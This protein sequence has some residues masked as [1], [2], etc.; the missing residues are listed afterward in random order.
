MFC[1]NYKH[2]I[3][4][5]AMVLGLVC[6]FVSNS[7]SY[8][9]PSFDRAPAKSTL[10]P[11]T[12]ITEPEF[13]EKFL[14]GEFLLAHEAVNAYIRDQIAREKEI[15]KKDWGQRAVQ[16]DVNDPAV[17][18]NFQQVVMGLRSVMVVRISGLLAHTG[19]F[20]HIG[21]SGKDYGGMPVIYIDS[22][23]SPDETQTVLRHEIDELL[24]WE[25]LRVNGLGIDRDAMRQWIRGHISPD[26]LPDPRLDATE[27][28][29]M[30]SRQIAELFHKSAFLLQP[31][32]GHFVDK[33][34]FNYEYLNL[35]LSLYGF[36][37]T[38]KDVNLAAQMP[39]SGDTAHN[40]SADGNRELSIVSPELSPE[41]PLTAREVIGEI[42]SI[43]H[44]QDI[45]AMIDELGMGEGD[46][47]LLVGVSTNATYGV[48]CAVRAARVDVAQP[49]GYLGACSQ[50]ALLQEYTAVSREAVEYIYGRDL[51]GDRIDMES[52]RKFVQ[53]AGLPARHYSYIFLPNVLDDPYTAE[54]ERVMGAV[55]DALT[56]R[57]TV[58]IGSWIR[59]QETIDLFR[60]YAAE[61]GY[62]VEMGRTFSLG[63]DRMQELIVTRITLQLVPGT[64]EAVPGSRLPVPRKE[65][66][67]DD[68]MSRGNGP[69]QADAGFLDA[70]LILRDWIVS[71]CPPAAALLKRLNDWY[72]E[73]H[74]S[75]PSFASGKT[76]EGAAMSASEDGIV[77]LICQNLEHENFATFF[78][79]R[80]MPDLE[81]AF[82]R[83]GLD[84]GQRVTVLAG[85][86]RAGKGYGNKTKDP[87]YDES[88]RM[89]FYDWLS[90]YF[91]EDPSHLPVLAAL[92][93]RRLVRA[94]TR[95]ERQSHRDA[96]TTESPYPYSDLN[97][98]ERSQSWGSG[99]D[100]SALSAAQLVLE[101]YFHHQYGDRKD[102][103]ASFFDPSR[104]GLEICPG[105]N[106]ISCGLYKTR[107][108]ADI[109]AMD[110]DYRAVRIARRLY[111][112]EAVRADLAQRLPYP[113]SVF[114]YV[115][116]ASVLPYVLEAY[117]AKRN[118]IADELLRITRP[119]GCHA[120][121]FRGGLV[122]D[123]DIFDHLEDGD[124]NGRCFSL[125]MVEGADVHGDAYIRYLDF[126]AHW[127]PVVS[128]LVLVRTDTPLTYRGTPVKDLIAGYPGSGDILRDG[129]FDQA[130]SDRIRIRFLK[131]LCAADRAKG[132]ARP[133]TVEMLQKIA[134]TFDVCMIRQYA[135]GLLR[136]FGIKTEDAKLEAYKEKCHEDMRRRRQEETAGIRMGAMHR[137]STGIRD[138][139]GPAPA[140]AG[141]LDALRIV[142][143]WIA[144]LCPPAAAFL[145]NLLEWYYELHELSP[146]DTHASMPNPRRAQFAMVLPAKADSF[147]P[148]HSGNANQARIDEPF[149]GSTMHNSPEVR[150]DSIDTPGLLMHGVILF[151]REAEKNRERLREIFTGGVKPANAVSPELRWK[152]AHR[153]PDWVS[154]SMVGK[155]GGYRD[156]TTHKSFGPTNGD[157]GRFYQRLTSSFIA[158]ILDPA[159]VR[160]H[161]SDFPAVGQ[162]FQG[163]MGDYHDASGAVFNGLEYSDIWK[164]DTPD[165]EPM[166]DEVWSRSIPPDAIAA[167]IVSDS[168]APEVQHLL[169][170]IPLRR[171]LRVFNPN[172]T[173]L[174]EV[175]RDAVPPARQIAGT[176]G[177]TLPHDLVP[178]TKPIGN[179]SPAAVDA[180]ETTPKAPRAEAGEGSRM[181]SQSYGPN[182][183]FG[184]DTAAGPRF[185]SMPGFG[186]SFGNMA[187]TT[188]SMSRT[189]AAPRRE[190]DGMT[191]G[192][193]ADV[194]NAVRT[195]DTVLP[196]LE[197]ADQ[198][199]YYSVRYDRTRIPRGSLAEAVL[200]TYV[201]VFLPCG[202]RGKDRVTLDSS[203]KPGQGLIWVECYADQARSR[204]IGEGHVD[205][206]G[207]IAAV[208]L[209]IP[210]MMDIALVASHIPADNDLTAADIMR[211]YDKPLSFIRGRYRFI[212]GEIL[213]D[214]MLVE[215]TLKDPAKGLRL[216]LPHA[217]PI[218][219]DRIP[220]YY[221]LTI[222]QL[223]QSA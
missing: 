170:Q 115:I 130:A 84:R 194:Q 122:V 65:Y 191:D 110:K 89:Y 82:D 114:D 135:L 36:D 27:F 118:A 168:Y 197:K 140:D 117:P 137:S 34:D 202:M 190:T 158:V 208:A 10:S 145:K 21:L 147:T 201:N 94:L 52:Y 215:E 176:P 29:G 43:P 180:P 128:Y 1:S 183:A 103:A 93:P 47:V 155:L 69:A 55:L 8:A 126:A 223:N 220:A 83:A 179:L 206:G 78:R 189:V 88:S 59:K 106:S 153:H 132:R 23:F 218:P 2:T 195:R 62:A 26:S 161:A 71:L 148:A 7:V 95:I 124:N 40:S 15:F 178:G 80:L 66:K 196:E 200:E 54:R 136:E 25:N 171:S 101:K 213:T 81:N 125:Y 31:L 92:P 154:L 216:M 151:G 123:D 22:Q 4:Y 111:G 181:L 76:E 131:A 98:T 72:F 214:K 86:L 163:S 193:V 57:G 172:G 138:N 58:C 199:R 60:Q 51:V 182:A 14:A 129:V 146:P 9:D 12:Q 152:P 133:E 44:K 73:L 222:K 100:A 87:R 28:R 157:Y 19:Q 134:E 109:R 91:W 53:D 112:V 173:V 48:A 159:Y 75:G 42:T 6:L 68:G 16:L 121:S 61:N 177:D 79:E 90:Y 107:Y 46:N 74:E 20:A 17:R 39:A 166:H 120:Y 99:S 116:A 205:I 211:D 18:G 104:K 169:A 212:T 188:N 113:D 144:S 209:R 67:A 167:I 207:D 35:M 56:D 32:Y 45:A 192:I 143:D 149:F 108:G 24:Q 156:T 185:L 11:A 175:G 139:S 198:G 142:R 210:A 96:S 77:S 165:G 219:P 187:P 102:F 186:S 49:D 150:I 41:L 105:N 70:L 13:R 64:E 33:V 174:F 3:L 85:L 5:R 141:F 217:A 164:T 127:V 50:T 221:E 38:A 97:T 160:A 63:R 184:S 30:T 119:G 204:K 203:R 162:G 37:E